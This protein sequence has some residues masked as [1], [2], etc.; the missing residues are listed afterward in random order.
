MTLPRAPSPT[1]SP[2][3]TDTRTSRFNASKN[4]EVPHKKTLRLDKETEMKIQMQSRVKNAK[5]ARE[6]SKANVITTFYQKVN[7]VVTSHHREKKTKML[8]VQ[9]QIERYVEN[10]CQIYSKGTG[11][12]ADSII[13]DR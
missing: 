1:L 12:R 13:E 4:P 7:N 2:N 5:L 6:S 11:G 10:L 9:S 3:P 8:D